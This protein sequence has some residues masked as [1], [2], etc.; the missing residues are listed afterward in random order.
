MDSRE[1]KPFLMTVRRCKRCG[2]ILISEKSIRRGYGP[3]CEQK[4]R[5]EH[6]EQEQTGTQ[7][8]L[9]EEG[10]YGDQT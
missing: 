3:C 2:G 10:S 7:F 5:E 4:E 8:S 1:N 6:R 9:F